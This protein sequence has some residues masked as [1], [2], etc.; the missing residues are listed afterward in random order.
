MFTIF[1]SFL[2]KNKQLNVLEELVAETFYRFLD[3]GFN[4]NFSIFSYLRVL[5]NIKYA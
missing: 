4:Y 1:S 2:L 5:S 3:I